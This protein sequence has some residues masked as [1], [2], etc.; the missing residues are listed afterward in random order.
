MKLA[1][2]TPLEPVVNTRV[3]FYASWGNFAC[4]QRRFLSAYSG[5]GENKH[6]WEAQKKTENATLRI[7]VR[8]FGFRRESDANV[9][10]FS[11]FVLLC[12][13]HQTT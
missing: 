7:L 5:R 10:R 13:H 12:S 2:I 9:S 1:S 4:S 11:A 6:E 3:M 8:Y